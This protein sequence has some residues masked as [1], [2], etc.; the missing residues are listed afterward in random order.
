MQ[1]KPVN[2]MAQ[3]YRE[4]IIEKML[5]ARKLKWLDQDRENAIQQNGA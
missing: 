3:K 4:F 2:V 5:P 1:A